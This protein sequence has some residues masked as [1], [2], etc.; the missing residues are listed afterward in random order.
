MKA[1]VRVVSAMS[2]LQVVMDFGLL[3]SSDPMGWFIP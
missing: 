3:S 1:K 2:T